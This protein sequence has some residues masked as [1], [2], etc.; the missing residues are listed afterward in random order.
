MMAYEVQQY[1]VQHGWINN[2]FYADDF[3]RLVLETFDT[4]EEAQAALVEYLEDLAK[5]HA[6]GQ[7][8]TTPQ[9]WDFR[10]RYIFT[11]RLASIVR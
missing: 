4:R 1:S 6:A 9:P 3:D 5:E 7:I 8:A 2:W 10:I 11:T